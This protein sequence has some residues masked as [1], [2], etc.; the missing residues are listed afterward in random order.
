[1]SGIDFCNAPIGCNIAF[2]GIFDGNGHVVSNLLIDTDGL[3]TQNLGLFGTLQGESSAVRNLAVENCSITG[4]TDSDNLGGLCGHNDG[5]TIVNCHATGSISG[6]DNLGGLCGYNEAGAIENCYATVSVTGGISTYNLGGLCGYNEAGSIVYC[7][8][9]GNIVGGTSSY[10]LGGLCGENSGTIPSC[11]ATGN[12]SGGSYLG[13]L[14]GETSGTTSNSY[15]TGSISGVDYLGGLFGKNS[16]TTPNSY[17]TGTVSGRNYIGGLCGENSGT[18]TNCYAIGTVGGTYSY[19]GLCGYNTSGTISNSFW[20]TETSGLTTSNGGTG[21]TTLEMQM[22]AT[23]TNAGWNFQDIWAM[24]SYPELKSFSVQPSEF[25]TWLISQG[26]PIN[27]RGA[28]DC[29]MLDGIANLLKYACGL[30]AMQVCSNGIYMAIQTNNSSSTFSMEYYKSPTATGVLLQPTWTS[31]LTEEVWSSDDITVEFVQNEG[32]RELW[33]ASIPMNNCGYM[34]L[35]ATTDYAP[36]TNTVG[37]VNLALNTTVTP[38]T[39]VQL[40]SPQDVVDGNFS[41]SWYSFQGGMDNIISFTLDIGREVTVGRLLYLPRQT[42]SYL[43]ETSSDNAEWTSRHSETIPYNSSVTRTNDVLGVYAARY[44]RYTGE[45]GQN[46]YTG[47]A[48]FQVFE[49]E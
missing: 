12:V 46:G 15:A 37:V 25:N 5:I 16:G 32:D 43:V 6:G 40:G 22:E 2:T 38:I 39:N 13:G 30:P 24:A 23:F 42:E 11:Y 31:N 17:A 45:N 41:T 7:Y 26:I 14:C 28:E 19:G 49:M 8:A 21:K 35:H 48:E 33:R 27:T 44:F 36:A 34:R 3:N 47:V 29:P 1:L 18:I 20:D 9:T 4:G 10:N